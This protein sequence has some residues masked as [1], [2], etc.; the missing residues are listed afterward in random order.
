MDSER[1]TPWEV[2]TPIN[3]REP[4]CMV[5]GQRRANRARD[6]GHRNPLAPCYFL[7]FQGGG[8]CD[9]QTW[10]SEN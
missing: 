2:M 10:H 8:D 7:S 9:Q 1:V 3:I 5:E 4:L 6:S